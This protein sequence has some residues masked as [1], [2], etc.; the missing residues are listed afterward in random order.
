MFK[1]SILVFPRRIIQ[2]KSDFVGL[3]EYRYKRDRIR[4]ENVFLGLEMPVET[5]RRCHNFCNPL[6]YFTRGN[7]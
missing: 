2:V 7:G 4:L 1:Y 5:L 6:A 3:R